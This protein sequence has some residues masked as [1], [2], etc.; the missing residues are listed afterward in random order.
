MFMRNDANIFT[1]YA[2][3]GCAVCPLMQAYRSSTS[4]DMQIAGA[5]MPCGSEAVTVLNDRGI[6]FVPG[7]A[8]NAGKQM[9]M[10][11]D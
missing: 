8:A 9:P 11:H 6:T 2:I 10:C 4:T 5:N 1:P 7:K 3:M